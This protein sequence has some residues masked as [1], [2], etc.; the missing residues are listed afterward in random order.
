MS[1]ATEA[2]EGNLV[3][4]RNLV[5]RTGSV[6]ILAPVTLYIV[7]VGGV[8]FFLF[9]MLVVCRVTYEWDRLTG[10]SGA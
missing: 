8:I 6:V 9:L 1:A 4:L 2:L 10:G 5:A 3:L 7:W